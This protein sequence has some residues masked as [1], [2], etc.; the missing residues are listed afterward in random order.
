M[1]SL[2]TA[3]NNAI[4]G[5]SSRN[6]KVKDSYVYDTCG[7]EENNLYWEAD[8]GQAFSEFDV[9]EVFYHIPKTPIT[10]EFAWDNCGF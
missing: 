7:P 3:G 5:V 1:R 9:T 6:I 4:E 2:W 8:K 10:L